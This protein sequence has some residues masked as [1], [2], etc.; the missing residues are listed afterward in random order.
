GRVRWIGR[1]RDLPPD[2]GELAV[3]DAEGGCVLPGFVDP[4]THLVWAGSRR[5]ELCARLAGR[6][7]DGGGI[8]TT[9]AAT[10]ATPSAELVRLA[11]DRARAALAAGTTTIE[12]KTGYGLTVGEELRLLDVIADLGRRTPQAVEATYLVHVP[13]RDRDRAAHVA[14]TVAALPEARRRGARWC[15]VF[16]DRG[17]FSPEEAR[18][19][20]VAARAAGLGL[21][22]HADQLERTGAAQLAAAVGCASADHLDRVDEAGASALARSATVAVLLP[23]AALCTGS[24]GGNGARLLRA[25]GVPL[26]LGTDC[27]PGTSWCESMPYVVQVACFA[28]GLSV[29]EALTAAT[30][31]SARALHLDDAGHLAPGA[32]GDL[33][34]LAAEHEADLVAHLGAPAVRRVVVAGRVQD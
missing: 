22:L 18:T 6:R 30:R 20:L 10:T 24:G 4:H 5:A 3:L 26:A 25:A 12:V 34:V 2:L 14:E 16:C 33:V 19:L 23:T 31:G 32:R 8:H 7:Y 15:D 9:V 28:T 13:P 21:R 1:E 27:N 11:E 17:A 29:G